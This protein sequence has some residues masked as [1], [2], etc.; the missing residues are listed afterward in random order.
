MVISGALPINHVKY[1]RF[2]FLTQSVGGATSRLTITS[3]TMA[4]SLTA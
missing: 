1:E 2:F 3:G 4:G